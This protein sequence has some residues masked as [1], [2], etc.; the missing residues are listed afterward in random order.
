MNSRAVGFPAWLLVL[1]LV[2][3]LLIAAGALRL[4]VPGFDLLRGLSEPLA[5][6]AIGLGLFCLGLF[7]L[8]FLRY[9]RAR[10]VLGRGLKFRT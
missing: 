8:F 1:D 7:W 10:R 2:A 4:Y 5:W 6:G 3:V 9:L